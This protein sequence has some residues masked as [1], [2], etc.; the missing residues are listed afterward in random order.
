MN[1][2]LRNILVFIVA[3]VIFVVIITVFPSTLPMIAGLGFGSTMYRAF[4]WIEYSH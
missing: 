2:N 3:T 4:P 1:W